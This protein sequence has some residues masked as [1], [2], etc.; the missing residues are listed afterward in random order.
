MAQPDNFGFCE[1]AALLKESARKFFADS[2]STDQ[3]HALVAPD[4]D[5]YRPLAAPWREDLWRQMVELGCIP[6]RCG[7]SGGL[8]L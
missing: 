5:P 7:A 6:L 1:E 3:L 4:P 8:S 2:F